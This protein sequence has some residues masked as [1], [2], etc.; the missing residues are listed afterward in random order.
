MNQLSYKRQTFHS[1]GR[2]ATQQRL[3]ILQAIENLQGQ[4]TPQSLY[5]SLQQTHPEIGLVT[6]YRTL[7]LLVEN[8]LVCHMGQHGRS[9]NYARSPNSYP[10]QHHHHIICTQCNKVVDITHCKLEEMVQELARDTGFDINGHRLEFMGRC[11][12]CQ[13]TCQQTKS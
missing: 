1:N 13:N 11:R 6:V 7:K 10:Q 9:Q 5:S 8:N 4:F 2:K 3:I 12:Q